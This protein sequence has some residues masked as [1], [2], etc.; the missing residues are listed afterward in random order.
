[1]NIFRQVHGQIAQVVRGLAERGRLP[2]DLDVS[3]IAVEPPRDP[4]H[5]DIASNA[6]MVLASAARMLISQNQCT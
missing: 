6:A 5:G 4:A 2:G 1:M 3:R